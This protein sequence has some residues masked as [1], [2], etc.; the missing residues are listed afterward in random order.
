MNDA[1]LCGTAELA[2]LKNAVALIATGLRMTYLP[3]DIAVCNLSEHR[4]EQTERLLLIEVAVKAQVHVNRINFTP[5]FFDPDDGLL[6]KSFVLDGERTTVEYVIHTDL[7]NANSD[8]PLSRSMNGIESF[9]TDCVSYLQL[10][11]EA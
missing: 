3:K 9:L 5:L 1:M 10:R 11:A 7:S 8:V 2:E 6:K 4:A